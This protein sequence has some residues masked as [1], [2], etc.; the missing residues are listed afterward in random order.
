MKDSHLDCPHEDRKRQPPRD[1]GIHVEH[2][3]SRPGTIHPILAFLAGNGKLL[4]QMSLRSADP[5]FTRTIGRA[6]QD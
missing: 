5:F 4:E 3:L 2:L 6:A 1:I